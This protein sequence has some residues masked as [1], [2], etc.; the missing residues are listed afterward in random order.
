MRLPVCHAVTQSLSV[1]ELSALEPVPIS[2]DLRIMRLGAANGTTVRISRRAKMA[3]MYELHLEAE[4]EHG[5]D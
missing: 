3:F 5:M 2:E 1:S 4:K